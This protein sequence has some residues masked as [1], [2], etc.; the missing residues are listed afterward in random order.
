MLQG[1]APQ[2]AS[3]AAGPRWVLGWQFAAGEYLQMSR[4]VFGDDGIQEVVMS[5]S[6]QGPADAGGGGD[7]QA[8]PP[9]GRGALGQKPQHIAVF[10]E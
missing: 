7:A 6:L 5:P 10:S 9:A 3:D 1:A 8:A 4:D 2:P